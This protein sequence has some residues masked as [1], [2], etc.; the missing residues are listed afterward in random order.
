MWGNTI[1]LRDR[2]HQLYLIL[3]WEETLSPF[4]PNECILIEAEAVD[5]AMH[6]N[7][8]ILKGWKILGNYGTPEN[9]KKL[10]RP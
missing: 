2:A 7:Y 1:C 3:N 4:E 9:P 10:P 6:A 5:G 8:K